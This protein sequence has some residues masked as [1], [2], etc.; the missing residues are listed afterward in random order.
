FAVL[1]DMPL[2]PDKPVSLGV[3]EFCK[4]CKKCADS[5]PSKS[6]PQGDKVIFNGFEKWKLDEDSCYDYWSKVGTDCSICMAICPFSR[7]NTF[8]HKF[9]RLFVAKSKIAQILFP[10]IDNFLY[11]KRW[12][13]KTVVPWL[14][15]KEKKHKDKTE[16]Y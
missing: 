5:C 1:T 14:D 7:P 15:Y 6:I 8:L 11:G 16:V 2:I 13:P 4:S 3:E 9:V 12:R 10:Y